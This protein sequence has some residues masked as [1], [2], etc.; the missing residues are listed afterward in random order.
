MN[1]NN[2]TYP[3]AFARYPLTWAL[4]RRGVLFLLGQD[5]PGQR[6]A[7]GVYRLRRHRC[8]FF[9]P[10]VT[11]QLTEVDENSSTFILEGTVARDFLPLVFPSKDTPEAK[12]RHPERRSNEAMRWSIKSFI[13]LIFCRNYCFL[14]SSLP[15][16]AS[17][18]ES[19]N[20]NK[21]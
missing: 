9:F 19:F 18:A 15:E 13:A 6:H 11:T 16:F 21:Y 2:L 10:S 17:I 3:V 7:V 1:S 12:V 5:P 14:A 8:K 20:N 4:T